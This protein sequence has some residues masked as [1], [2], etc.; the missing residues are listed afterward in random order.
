MARVSQLKETYTV[1]QSVEH[2]L[3]L[4]VVRRVIKDKV[5]S[6]QNIFELQKF[7]SHF[8]YSKCYDQIFMNL[9]YFVYYD[10][11]DFYNRI[12][13]LRKVKKNSKQWYHIQMGDEGLSVYNKHYFE[14]PNLKNKMPGG[15]SSKAALSFFRHVDQ[16]LKDHNMNVRALYQD[17]ENNKH[18]FRIRDYNLKWFSYDYTIKEL[19]LI[20]EYHGEHCH[21]KKEQIGSDW[22]QFHSNESAEIVFKRDLYKQQIAESKGYKYHVIWHGDSMNVKNQKL[23]EIFNDFKI[24]IPVIVPK[25]YRTF[26]LTKPNGEEEIITNLDNITKLYGLSEYRIS[27]LKENKIK[28]YDGYQLRKIS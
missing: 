20:I 16:I 1:D 10:L 21:P 12:Q 28:S 7:F 26:L 22:K 13:S 9:A 18:E 27:Q 4:L 5:V 23:T 8:P 15:R 11:D 17:N 25:H 3:K 24:A 6:D 14:N 2:F 19:N